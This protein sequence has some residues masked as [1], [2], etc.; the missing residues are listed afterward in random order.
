[1]RPVPIALIH[2]RTIRLD[3]FD[4]EVV[5]RAEAVVVHAI[6]WL[7]GLPFRVYRSSSVEAEREETFPGGRRVP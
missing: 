4:D 2:E 6:A 3:L 1:M 5:F 7:Q